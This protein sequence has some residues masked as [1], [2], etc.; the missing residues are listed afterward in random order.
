MTNIVESYFNR[1]KIVVIIFYCLFLFA[2]PLSLLEGS[3]KQILQMVWALCFFTVVGFFWYYLWN[4][5]KLVG[6]RPLL[7]VFLAIFLSV[8]GPVV[9][10][11]VLKKAYFNLPP[12]LT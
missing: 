2:Y 11:L 10:Y 3:T 5:A 4:C 12:V 7:Y 9:T 1:F 6:K 8:F